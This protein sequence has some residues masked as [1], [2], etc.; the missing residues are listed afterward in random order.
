MEKRERLYYLDFIRAIGTIIIVLTHYN[1]IFLYTNP[2]MP[3]KAV[4]STTIAGIYIGNFG[5]ALFLIISGAAL[6]YVYK[7][8]IDI[9]TFYI[10]R[11]W[12]IYPTFWIAFAIMFLTKFYFFGFPTGTA[13]WRIIFS[14][15]GIDHYL[16][17]HG[18]STFASVGEWFLGFII[19]FYLIFP[20]VRYA[21]IRFP[22]WTAIISIFLYILVIWIQPTAYHISLFTLLP[23]ILFGMY[24][25]YY[26]KTVS[27]PIAIVSLIIMI[28]NG[29]IKPSINESIQQ[30]YIGICAFLFLVFV[31]KYF[32][33][34]PIPK[35]ANLI[36]KYSYTIF[37]V[38]HV[39]TLYMAQK[40]D[41]YTMTRT[42]SYMLFL[43]C[44]CVIFV[45]AYLV[46]RLERAAVALIKNK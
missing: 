13:K 10:K 46:Q 18:I 38:H 4:I 28:G 36:C 21:M 41:L 19:I 23:L 30:T 34:N 27:M 2:Q 24:F 7:E 42:D 29:I 3:E 14:I 45:V 20:L 25:V 40:F 22:K 31:S 32:K 5:V 44:C 11:F 9:K 12:N 17:A 8:K 35:V 33:W 37:I 15:L 39:I 6:M 43:C 16:G 1:A 26:G